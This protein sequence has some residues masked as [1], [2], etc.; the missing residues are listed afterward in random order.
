MRNSARGS[1]QLS[2]PRRLAKLALMAFLGYLLVGLPAVQA[3]ST[4]VRPSS[5][6]VQA[7]IT[8]TYDYVTTEGYPL[9]NGSSTHSAEDS[10]FNIAVN[11]INGSAYPG[12]FT[13]TETFT[14]YNNATT[15]Q[16]ATG[17]TYIFNPYDNV[18]YLGALGFYPLIYT[19]VQSG[20]VERL[21][22]VG[23]AITAN[24]TQ[25]A[26]QTVN[27][28]IGRSGDTIE[29]NYTETFAGNALTYNT[30]SFNATT[31]VLVH[32]ASL[33]DFAF[34][35]RGFIYTLLSVQKSSNSTPWWLLLL[36]LVFVVVIVAAVVDWGQHRLRRR[37]KKS[38]VW[39]GRE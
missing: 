19:D 30:L 28:S 33:V 11:S 34:T 17:S 3:V 14:K 7:G 21:K 29:V 25:R 39:K 27:A 24:G 23:S 2:M 38:K 20:T 12:V 16:A 10:G 4:S 8:I 15:M 26:S 32:G 5:I 6:G 31:G 13:Y 22:L 37:G 36:P 1:S 18:T 9:P 35:E